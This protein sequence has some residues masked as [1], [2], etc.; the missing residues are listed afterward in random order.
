MNQLFMQDLPGF[1][2]IVDV[3][4]WGRGFCAKH[5][6]AAIEYRVEG[7]ILPISIGEAMSRGLPVYF[8]RMEW[9]HT[10]LASFEPG[11]LEYGCVY[12]NHT[13]KIS[14]AAA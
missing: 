12:C 1:V 7:E 14:N 9:H 2:K 5:A 6:L 4:G 10:L 13:S 11:T 3:R 8:E